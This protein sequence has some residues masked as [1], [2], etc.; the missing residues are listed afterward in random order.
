MSDLEDRIATAD[1]TF[2][3]HTEVAG[4]AGEQLAGLLAERIAAT[5]R[6]TWPQATEVGV[7]SDHNL[8]VVCTTTATLAD[9]WDSQ[10]DDVADL[11]RDDLIRIGQTGHFTDDNR[12]VRFRGGVVA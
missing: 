3:H 6:Q 10:F 8:D 9:G 12:V 4:R 11:V 7:D 5:V 2:T 1:A